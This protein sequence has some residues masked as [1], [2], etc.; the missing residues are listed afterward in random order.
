MQQQGEG[1]QVATHQE[2][3]T[4]HWHLREPGVDSIDSIDSITPGPWGRHAHVDADDA[5][6]RD[7]LMYFLLIL[8]LISYPDLMCPS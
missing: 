6:T 8:H 7:K 5:W 2:L 4:E 3:G 1:V